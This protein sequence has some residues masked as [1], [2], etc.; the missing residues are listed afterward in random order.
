MSNEPLLSI[1]TVSAFDGKRLAKTLHSLAGVSSFIEHVVVIPKDD[2]E[3]MAIWESYSDSTP[4]P[5]LLVHDERQGVYPA[6]NIGANASRGKYLCYWNAGDELNSVE[7]L[8]ILLENLDAGNPKWVICQGKFQWRQGQELS[9][10]NLFGFIKHKAYSFISH[11]TVIVRRDTFISIGSF[12]CRYRVAADTAMI[13]RMCSIE[14][15]RWEESV[16]VK[17]EAPQFASHNHRLG[18]I[19]VLLIALRELQGSQR[20]QALKNIFYAETKRL[21]MKLK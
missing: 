16:V 8:Q 11:Q 10:L 20:I 4:H 12:D 5:M 1:I 13:T 17:V 14:N 7:D 19:E 6:M 18:R 21:V 3:S 2:I 15:P 9:V